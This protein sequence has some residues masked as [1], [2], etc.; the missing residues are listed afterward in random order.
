[1]VV[2]LIHFKF[3]SAFLI[4]LMTLIAAWL[5]FKR[6]LQSQQGY[7]FPVAEALACGVFLGA[8]LIHMLGDASTDFQ[9]LGFHYPLAFLL[10]G[11]VFLFLLF[12]EHLSVDL[13]HHHEKHEAIAVVAVVMLSIHS[14]LAGAALGLSGSLA[15]GLLVLIAILAH[16]W[17]ASFALAVQLNKSDL[18][19]KSIVIYFIVF[20]V[21]APLG[22]I[23]GGELSSPL[24]QY[25][26]LKPIFNSLAA[27][28]FLY[29][30]T[31]HGLNR[32]VMV[33]HCCNLRE[34]IWVIVGFLLMAVVAIWT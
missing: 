5:P 33:K 16:K 12:L 7:Q 10:A 24:N 14:L 2:G 3:L 15:S 31:L 18:S 9:K 11:S 13:Q 34:Y 19:V 23:A 4:L 8:G 28:T 22:V 1:M 32:A 20:A 26:V 29:I 21:M 17:A 6:R 30:G 27:G 25:Q